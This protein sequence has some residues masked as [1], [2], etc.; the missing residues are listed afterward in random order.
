MNGEWKLRIDQLLGSQ[1]RELQV[2]GFS[3]QGLALRVCGVTHALGL[4]L[5]YDA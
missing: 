3:V 1:N 5:M 2:A 4:S